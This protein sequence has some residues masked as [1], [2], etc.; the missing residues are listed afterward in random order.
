MVDEK[1]NANKTRVPIPIE[2]DIPRGLMTSFASNM[3]V[4]SIENVFKI[5][6]FEINPPIQLDE[7]APAPTK[8]RADCVASVIVTPDKLLSFTEVLQKQYKKY[9]AEKQTE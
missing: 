2:W 4:Q 6:F 5:S 1:T 8:I 3:V 9:M 7:S